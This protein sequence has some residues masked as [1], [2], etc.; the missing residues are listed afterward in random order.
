M[1]LVSPNLAS[2]IGMQYSLTYLELIR[3]CIFVNI[4]N[5]LIFSFLF[6]G[7]W[8]WTSVVWFTGLWCYL[9]ISKAVHHSI[10]GSTEKT[11]V[12]NESWIRGTNSYEL[13][14]QLTGAAT[15]SSNFFP[16]KLSWWL[17]DWLFSMYFASKLYLNFSSVSIL[18]SLNK[19]N[20][21][22]LPYVLQKRFNQDKR[23]V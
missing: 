9:S 8:K 13:F 19:N 2:I 7:W 17:N 10:P 22:Y 6:R 3:N 14:F 18:R 21:K 4:R 20:S 5:M 16:T 1:K 12:R 11:P 23:L 15:L